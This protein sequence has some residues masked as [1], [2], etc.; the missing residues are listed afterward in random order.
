[1][2]LLL[3]AT[4]TQT[5]ANVDQTRQQTCVPMTTQLSPFLSTLW[6]LVSSIAMMDRMMLLP[7]SAAAVDKR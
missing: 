4:A 5:I 6:L 3:P 1:M 7:Y 2:W